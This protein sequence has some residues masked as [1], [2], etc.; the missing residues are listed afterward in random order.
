[1]RSPLPLLILICACTLLL[2]CAGFARWLRQYTYPPDFRYIEREQLRSAMWQL[3]HHVRELDREIE[4]A[5]TQ[6]RR[7]E[8]VAHLAGMDAAVAT[9]D[10]TGWPSNHPL[11]DMNLARFRRDIRLAREAAERDPPSLVLARS[12]TAACVYCHGGR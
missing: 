4:S 9:L 7:K 2:G 1:M 12:L 10:S 8:I 6:D 5:E 11:V 3:A